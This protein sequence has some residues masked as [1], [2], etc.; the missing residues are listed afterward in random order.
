MRAKKVLEFLVP[1]LYLEKPIKVTITIVNTIIRALTGER[2]VDSALLIRNVIHKLIS[3]V[4]KS[5]SPPICPYM[6][7]LYHYLETMRGN[8][9][10]AY[11]I[12]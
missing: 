9:V 12:A 8:E 7:H 5:K 1:I 11:R 6:F 2:K 10:N 3:K 4:K